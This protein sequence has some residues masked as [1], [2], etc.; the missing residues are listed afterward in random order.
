M[1]SSLTKINFQNEEEELKVWTRKMS[2]YCSIGVDAR[3]GFGF[4]KNRTKSKICNKIVY[5]WEGVKKF[6]C[7][8]LIRMKRII[9]K[10]E[11]GN[12]VVDESNPLNKKTVFHTGSLTNSKEKSVNELEDNRLLEIDPINLIM[13]NIPSYMAGC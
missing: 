5:A 4:D 1:K 2:N 10:L 7:L 3:I 13:L 11:E 6:F 9:K 8:K 12:G